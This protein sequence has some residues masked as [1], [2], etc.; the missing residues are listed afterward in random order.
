V[1][2]IGFS[3]QK[4]LQKGTFTASVQAYFYSTIIFSGPWILSILTILFLN[5]FSPTN[6]NL[7]DMIFFRTIIVYIF[8]ISFVTTGF[9]HF[10][11]TRYLADKLYVGDKE[12]IV[13]TFN[14]SIFFIFLFQ[15][16]IATLTLGQVEMTLSLKVLITLIYM[17]MSCLWVTMI[18]LT[19]L[20]AFRV[21]SFFYLIGSAVT[22]GFSLWFGKMWGVDGYFLGY[23]IGHFMI[24][25]LW[26]LRIFIEFGS[27]RIFDP[28]IIMS[29]VKKRTL[30]FI[31]LFYNL[32]I[33]IDKII[34]WLTPEAKIVTAFFRTFPLY[35][36]PVFFAHLT[37]IPALSLLLIH[38]ETDFYRKF[39]QYYKGVLDKM[40]YL[41]LQQL[42]AEVTQSL[43]T[44]ILRLI[45]F[46]GTL[47][48]LIIV[49]AP[50][51]A[52]I[53]NIPWIQ[54]P[55]FRVAVLATFLHS[56]LLT[57]LIITLYFDFQS[58]AVVM[59]GLFFF[60]NAFFTLITVPM[61]NLF[62]GY[63]YLMST[64]ITLITALFM[65][66]AKLRRLEYYTFAL[67]PV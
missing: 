63:G 25:I 31:G 28:G 41:K 14:S 4:I 15:G 57:V 22:V 54:I 12:A 7:L 48:L 10:P 32:A 36:N 49:F 55:I 52:S 6:I 62:Y 50:Q 21:I 66:D 16:G 39:R 61:G 19:T 45:R 37:I 51:I 59:V 24:V 30:I 35:E 8:A 27:D 3:I 13:P 2:G 43:K 47:S 67:L 9:F 58:D 1:A 46:Q 17:T 29:L 11:L 42:R 18:F 20:K 5:I 34:F 56:L 44:S 38:I 64:L 53:V 26:S 33:W 60:T 23:L 40:P 65:F